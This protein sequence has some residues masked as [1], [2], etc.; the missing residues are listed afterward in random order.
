VDVSSTILATATPPGTSLRGIIRITGKDT[1]ELINLIS[2]RD[3]I[4]KPAV[5]PCRLQLRALNLP[6]IILTFPNPNSYTGE[7]SAE[8][9]IPGNP[10]LLR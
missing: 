4:T 10:A 1:F 3:I 6:A 8:I 5:L 9:Q 2:D 7:H